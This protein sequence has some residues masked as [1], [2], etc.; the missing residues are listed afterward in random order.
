MQKLCLSYRKG[1]CPSV[2]PSV[3]PCYFIKK[4]T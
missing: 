3:T 2:C 1:V 4:T